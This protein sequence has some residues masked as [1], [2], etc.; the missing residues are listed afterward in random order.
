M[1][2]VLDTSS[3]LFGFSNSVNVF[4]KAQEHFPGCTIV[5]SNGVISELEK[6]SKGNSKVSG[7]ARIALLEIDAYKQK[8]EIEKSRM[9]VDKWIEAKSRH[10]GYI[11]CTNDTALRKRIRKGAAKVFALSRSGAFS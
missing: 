1:R 9:Y 11:I 4:S 10:A 8:I 3:I 2:I 5:L 7:Y 6:L